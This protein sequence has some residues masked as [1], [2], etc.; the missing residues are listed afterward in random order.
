MGVACGITVGTVVNVGC[1]VFVDVGI[2]CVGLA[3]LPE[4]ET[5]VRSKNS[6]PISNVTLKLFLISV[7]LAVLHAW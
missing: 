4:H 7:I 6:E 5:I 2:G 1:T 3:S